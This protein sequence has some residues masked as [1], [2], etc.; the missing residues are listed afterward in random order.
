M[1]SNE[2]NTAV[3]NFFRKRVKI[4]KTVYQVDTVPVILNKTHTNFCLKNMVMTKKKE[5]FT[6]NLIIFAQ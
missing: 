2:P 6:L 5:D 3:T 4:L 1:F